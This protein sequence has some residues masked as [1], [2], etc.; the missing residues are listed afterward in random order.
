MS[1]SIVAFISPRSEPLKSILG[2]YGDV[3]PRSTAPNVKRICRSVSFGD[4]RV[5]RSPV[6]I[7]VAHVSTRNNADSTPDKFW[8]MVTGTTLPVLSLLD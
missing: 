6:G 2:A 4:L 1:Y 3:S 8:E 7:L 5:L